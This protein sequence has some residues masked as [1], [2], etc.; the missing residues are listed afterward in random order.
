[1]LVEL[2]Q[3]WP[4][5]VLIDAVLSPTPSRAFVDRLFL[6]PLPN[7]V[8]AQAIGI[9]LIMMVLKVA[10]DGLTFARS[11]VNRRVEFGGLIRVRSE[12]F[13]HLHRLGPDY[14]KRTPQGDAIYRMTFDAKRVQGRA[15]HAAE[16][17]SCRP[18]G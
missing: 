3:A 15:E 9:T 8:L 1:M 13:R 11:L 6:A 14:H 4:A 12:L 16:H 18:C 5:A 10:Q 2:A 17:G 7:N